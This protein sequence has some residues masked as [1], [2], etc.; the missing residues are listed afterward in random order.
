MANPLG[1]AWFESQEEHSLACAKFGDCIFDVVQE[2]ASALEI[3]WKGHAKSWVKL[4]D[5]AIQGAFFGFLPPIVPREWFL[6]V[7]FRPERLWPKA[8]TV[9]ER[10]LLELAKAA[11]DYHP[12]HDQSTK[13]AKDEK[14]EIGDDGS[15]LVA[16]QTYAQLVKR[17]IAIPMWKSYVETSKA[18]GARIAPLCDST[19][20]E[21][22]TNLEGENIFKGDLQ[23][24]WK[25]NTLDWSPP[26][27]R[28]FPVFL[29][30]ISP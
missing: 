19:Y 21:P 25:L 13:P 15:T 22:C 10:I 8:L 30:W 5:K 24:G 29:S 20:G 18:Y 27:R 23:R 4:V 16:L 3:S 26:T 7:L 12:L 2:G 28:V 1:N 11:S 17:N 6:Y 9:E 14:Y